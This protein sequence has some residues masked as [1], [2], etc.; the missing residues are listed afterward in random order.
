MCSFVCFHYVL[1]KQS[2][3]CAKN[4]LSYWKNKILKQ[5]FSYTADL[6]YVAV[7]SRAVDLT[8]AAVLFNHGVEIIQNS[9]SFFVREAIFQNSVYVIGV[10]KIYM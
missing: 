7:F 8:H 3:S 9:C 1:K 10:I 6:C 2:T 4:G 5:E